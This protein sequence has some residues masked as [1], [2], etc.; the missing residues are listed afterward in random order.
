M[1]LYLYY[2]RFSS[3]CQKVLIALYEKEVEFIAH[4][5]DLGDERSRAELTALWPHTKFPVLHDTG[6]ALTLP[7]SSSI[8][9]Y[10][11]GLSAKGPRLIPE[12]PDHARIVRQWDRILDNYLHIPMQKIV[13]DRLRPDDS[14]DPYGVEEARRT[15]ATTYS[16][17]DRSLPPTGW[18]GGR[19]FSLADCSAAPPLFYSSMVAPFGPGHPRL[20]AYL[21]RLMQ[22]P[23]FARCIDAARDFRAYFPGAPGDGPWPD[24][25]AAPAPQES[26]VAF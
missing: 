23:S 3:Y 9:E 24:E 7:E 11:D 2:H 21:D 22:R 14:R 26:R 10:V 13:G 12:R 17:L 25:A 8:I 4:E 5:V 20:S 19:E 6:A 15:I 16:L 18:L 1:A